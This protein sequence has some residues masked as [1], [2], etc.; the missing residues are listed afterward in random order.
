MN[1]DVK[2]NTFHSFCCNL[3]RMHGDMIKLPK[4]FHIISQQDTRFCLEK[5]IATNGEGMNYYEYEICLTNF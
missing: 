4:D 3:L 5:I 2:V 1:R